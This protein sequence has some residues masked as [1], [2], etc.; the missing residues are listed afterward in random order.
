MKGADGVIDASAKLVLAAEEARVD[1]LEDL[2]MR[3]GTSLLVYPWTRQEAL[4]P[5]R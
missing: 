4:T 2:A 3:L 5:V 1:N